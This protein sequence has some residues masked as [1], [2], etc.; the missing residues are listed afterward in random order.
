MTTF[1]CGADSPE[2]MAEAALGYR[3]ARAIKLKL[4]G[5]ASDADRVRAVREARQDVW[6]GVDANQGFTLEGLEN[7]VPVLVEARVKLIE[8]P[9]PVDHEKLL[10]YFVS[11]IPLA[12]DESMQTLSDLSVLVGGFN[13]VNIKLD[14]CGG[15]T[16]GLAIARA[17][18]KL[19]FQVMVET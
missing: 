4:T 5:E 11:L 12:A 6:M 15:L 9:L 19:G 16:D 1:T 18:R 2:K 13:V 17:A 8:Q 7:L 3:D 14:E 10:D